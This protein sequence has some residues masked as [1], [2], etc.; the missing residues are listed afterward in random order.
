MRIKATTLEVFKGREG[1][2]TS[3]DL[4]AECS[5]D[6]NHPVSGGC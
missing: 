1:G 5:H 4:I 3:H 6:M 2:G